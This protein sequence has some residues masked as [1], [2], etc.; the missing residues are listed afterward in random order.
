MAKLTSKTSK[1]MFPL[2]LM[3]DIKPYIDRI[4]GGE[5][6]SMLLADP[7]IRFIQSIGTSGGQPKLIPITAK[8]FKKRMMEP[9]LAEFV[10]KKCFTGLDE[11]KSFY[12]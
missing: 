6:S 4:A 12:L 9:L 10:L 1:Q 11:G 8:S 7:I 3:M 5:P 2:L